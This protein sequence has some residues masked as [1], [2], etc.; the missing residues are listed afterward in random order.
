LHKVSDLNS[1]SPMDSK[2]TNSTNLSEQRTEHHS[3]SHFLS[4]ECYSPIVML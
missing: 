1:F 3:M 2:H 4:L